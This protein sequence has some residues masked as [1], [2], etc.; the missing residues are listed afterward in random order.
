[1]NYPNGFAERFLNYMNAN[2]HLNIGIDSDGGWID[3]PAEGDDGDVKFGGRVYVADD[4]LRAAYEA[5][6]IHASHFYPDVSGEEATMA[7]LAL[8]IWEIVG[9]E[10]QLGPKNFMVEHIVERYLG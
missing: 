3:Y 10:T 7:M 2:S 1:M 6:S 9:N 8:S 5:I 4:Q